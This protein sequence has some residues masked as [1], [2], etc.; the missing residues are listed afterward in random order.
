MP[1]IVKVTENTWL[2]RAGNQNMS[3]IL[4]KKKDDIFFLT[5][6]H[7]EKFKTISDFEGK[8][9]TVKIVDNSASNEPQLKEINGYP[10]K[11]KDIIIID[12][13]DIPLYKKS[14]GSEVVYAAG[15]WIIGFSSQWASVLCPKADTLTDKQFRGPYKTNFEADSQLKN[16]R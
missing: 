1:Q 5:T 15:Y 6:T 9:G 2:V 16:Y 11:H 7:T 10:V 4:Q 13:G 8:Y 14:E 12:A 3:G